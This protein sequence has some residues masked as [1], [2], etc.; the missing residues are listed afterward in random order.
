MSAEIV[1]VDQQ[2]ADYRAGW[3]PSQDRT[4]VAEALGVGVAH[5]SIHLGGKFLR[6]N[7]C[8]NHGPEKCTDGADPITMLPRNARYRGLSSVNLQPAF[9][10]FFAFDSEEVI[11][12]RR[13]MQFGSFLRSGHRLRIITG[14]GCDAA[15]DSTR[16]KT[17]AYC[18]QRDDG[19]EV[20][21]EDQAD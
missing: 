6:V 10:A 21:G 4:D 13:A 2:Q 14:I 11:P 3:Q 16:A 18:Q 19:G 7:C 8:E 9:R 20:G 5:G 1:L 15:S 17:E 12:A